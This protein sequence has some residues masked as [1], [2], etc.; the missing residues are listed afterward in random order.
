MWLGKK[1]HIAITQSLS[2]DVTLKF[3]E[4]M[5]TLEQIYTDIDEIL[6]F[7][8]EKSNNKKHHRVASNETDSSDNEWKTGEEVI[9][10]VMFEIKNSSLSC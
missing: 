2:A 4:K 1:N 3:S 8:L 5:G 6:N 7:L 9:E 10:I